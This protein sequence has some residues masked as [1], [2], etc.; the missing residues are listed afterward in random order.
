MAHLNPTQQQRLHAII[1]THPLVRAHELREQGITAA[2]IS[3][4]EANGV[5]SRISRGLYQSLESEVDSYQSLAEVAKLVPDGV[6]CM[7]S[8]MA[9]HG[10]TDQM[11]RKVWVAIDRDAWVP[12]LSYPPIRTVRFTPE[13]HRQ[14]IEYHR[15]SGVQVP[16]YSIAKTLADVFR[17]PRLVDRSVAIE[18]LRSALTQRTVT[19]SEVFE[20][21]K[22]GRALKT[23][24]PYLEA[25]TSNG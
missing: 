19:P 23:I 8:A 17:N 2:T 5:I 1:K 4:A 12:T 18:S 13:F 16:I 6:I 22:V 20:A 24:K 21:A 10:L 9:Y 14:G 11:P 7:V 25:L 3:R 15:I